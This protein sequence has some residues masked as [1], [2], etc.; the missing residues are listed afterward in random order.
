[1][2]IK[3]HKNIDASLCGTP[4]KLG[5]GYSLVSLQTTEE[6]GVDE[7]GLV[8]GGFVFGMADYAAMIAV[9]HPHVVLGAAE[10][11]FL[12]PVRVGDVLMAEA[13]MEKRDEK[14]QNIYVRVV[15]SGEKVFEG[16]FICYV[17]KRHVLS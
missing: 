5:E 9:N 14:K 11:K 8:H 2:V 13:R 17:L 10:V 3:T 16:N 6:M 4:V 7:A 15:R 12:K 1:M